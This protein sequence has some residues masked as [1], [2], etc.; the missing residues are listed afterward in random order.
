MRCVFAFSRF[1]R[2]PFLFCSFRI[3]PF[4]RI[5]F[6]EIDWS[7]RWRLRKVWRL[8]CTNWISFLLFSSFSFLVFCFFFL[9][10]FWT[11]NNGLK[12]VWI[13]D[14]YHVENNE[15]AMWLWI[16]WGRWP[17][18][19]NKSI[20]NVFHTRRFLY[21][22]SSAVEFRCLSINSTKDYKFSVSSECDSWWI[23]RI[24]AH[25]PSG[26]IHTKCQSQIN[27]IEKQQRKKLKPKNK[28]IKK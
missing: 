27:N 15:I 13:S 17:Y 22:L 18:L 24:P 3:V 9:F 19:I 11:N 14:C 25:S 1:S 16:G 12:C 5:R 26:A 20:P 10:F 6:I 28:R 2:V 4:V 8:N 21:I 23:P 7:Q